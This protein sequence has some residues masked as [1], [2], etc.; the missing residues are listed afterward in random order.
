MKTFRKC[1]VLN[2][3]FSG[4]N[5]RWCRLLLPQLVTKE[6]ASEIAAI[7]IFLG[8]NDS[9]DFESNPRQHV[10]LA[11]YCDGLTDMVQYLMVIYFPM[12]LVN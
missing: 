9:N 8:A 11:E 7:T 4:Y 5:V 1:D 3:G 10:P 12:L 2:R 6:N